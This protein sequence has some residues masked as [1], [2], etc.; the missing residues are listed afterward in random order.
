VPIN[1]VGHAEQWDEVSIDGDIQ[2]KDCLLKYE[3]VLPPKKRIRKFM[4]HL[5][6]ELRQGRTAY[7]D[8]S[9]RNCCILFLCSF[10]LARRPGWQRV[11]L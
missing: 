2:A 1:Y 7:S 5:Q 8:S 11:P 6:R 10:S 4:R 3:V 9:L